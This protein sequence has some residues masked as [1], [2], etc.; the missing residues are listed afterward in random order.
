MKLWHCQKYKTNINEP[1]KRTDTDEILFS[2]P[3]VSCK[4][5][6]EGD[7]YCHSALQPE[8]GT[9]KHCRRAWRINIE[10]ASSLWPS[11]RLLKSLRCWHTFCAC[12]CSAPT[13]LILGHTTQFYF[14]YHIR[15]GSSSSSQ[16]QA[17]RPSRTSDDRATLD[18]SACRTD[19]ARVPRYPPAPLKCLIFKLTANLKSDSCTGKS[20]H[21]I[22]VHNLYTQTELT[23]Q[24]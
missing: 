14:H 7:S 8:N 4:N 10:C 3:D 21:R 17:I 1:T 22:A 2:S 5:A 23:F 18:P 12:L 24:D 11:R 13:D 16:I 9:L 15:Q 19:S 20:Y 6:I